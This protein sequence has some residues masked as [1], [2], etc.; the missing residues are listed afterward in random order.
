MSIQPFK[1]ERYYARHE[2][3]ARYMFSSSDCESLSLQELLGMASP[4]SITLWQNLGLGYTESQGNPLLREEIAHGQTGIGPKNVLIASPEEAIF[5]AMQTILRP[6]DRVVAIAPAYQSLHE[7]ARSIGCEVSNWEMQ[8][9]SQGWQLNMD[10]LEE[11]LSGKVRLLVINFPHNPTGFLPSRAQFDQIVALARAKNVMIFSDEM[12]RMLELNPAE[13]LPSISEVY[14][15]GLGLSGMS[16]SFSLP[17]LRIGWLTSQSEGLIRDIVGYKDYTTI[18]NSAPSELLAIIG[19]QNRERIVAR[20]LE[21]IRANITAAT[22]F[23]EKYRNLVEWQ[24]PQAGSIAFPRW[25]GPG[26]AEDLCEASVTQQGVMIVPGSMFDQPGERFR[27]GLGRR[28]F[29]Q[30]LEHL[31]EFFSITYSGV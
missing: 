21:I 6:G 27:V 20:N 7:I 8:P 28:N 12:Y 18:C 10:R 2:F 11:L 29:P 14:E 9:G 13:R 26:S 22:G 31:D 5:V 15:Q 24:P 16:K 4:A 1:L 17:G 3:N 30:A 19:L 25:L 23:F